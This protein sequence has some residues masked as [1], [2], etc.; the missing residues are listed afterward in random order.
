MGR[1]RR[2]PGLVTGEPSLSSPLLLVAALATSFLPDVPLRRLEVEPTEARLRGSDGFAQIVVTG[3]TK[4]DRLVDLTS[5]AKYES[6]DRRIVNVAHDGVLH[7]T[8]DGATDVVV[9]AGELSQTI[10][11]VVEDFANT[12][13][14]G[15]SSEVE[16]VFTK[17]GCNA[18][19]CHGKASGQNGFKLSLLGFDSK[20]DYD[21]IAKEA[22]GRR[23]FP[24]SPDRSLLLT[25]P[26]AQVP[27][28][29]G[30]K[31]TV[32]SMEYATLLRWVT[33]GMPFAAVR[34][35]TLVKVVV[36]PE[37]RVIPRREK[38]RLRVTA[39]YDDGTLL[40]VTRLAQYQ[41]NATDLAVVDEK[42]EITT[43]EGVGEAAVMARFGGLVA[44]TRATIPLGIDIPAWEP[45]ASRNVIDPFVFRKLRA[46]GI[47]PSPMC[48]D[49]EFARRTSLAICGVLPNPA[50]VDA[51]EADG[52]LDKRGTWVDRLL[53]RPEYADFF[54]LKWSA[55]LRNQRTGIAAIG[56]N[57][58]SLT[59]AFHAWIRQSLAENKPY[60]QFA[61]E[62]IAAKGD[63]A[64]NPPVSWYRQTG[65][66]MDDLVDDSAQLFLGMRIQ[67]ARCHHHPFEKWSQD[68]YF[69]FASFFSRVGRKTGAD[70]GSQ[71]LYVLPTGV[72]RNPTTGKTYSPKALDG[73]ELG[74]LGPRQDPRQELA[75]WL[76]RA[77]NPYF[78]KALVN[79][80]WKH[81]FGRGLVEPEDDMRVSNPPTNPEL[82]D[83]LAADFVHSGY[84]LKRLARTI[85]TS[86]AFDRSSEPNQF[87]E[88][89]HQNFARYYPTRLS[90]EVLLDAI[91]NVTGSPDPFAGVPKG[92]KAVQLPDEGFA[93]YFLDVFG[94]PKRESVCECER[95]SEANLSQ[96]LHLLNSGEIQAKLAY[97]AG[98]VARWADGA[99]TRTDREKIVELYRL[100]YSRRPTDE[101]S[102][103]C[104]TH[105]ERRKAENKPRQGYEDLVW[106]LIN[107]KEFLFN[108]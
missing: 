19:G 85:A 64:A 81:F 89:D 26:T 35:P 67:C 16:P 83:A 46:L 61:A 11:V 44:V 36:S 9:T 20:F 68:D 21:A 66:T 75:D 40:D 3:D 10:R 98:N 22:R 47:P 96:T 42:G 28:G 55:I 43:L 1:L 38:Q 104:S 65:R 2:A 95:S 87:N 74:E 27:H 5:V 23:V 101:E 82:L 25:K 45:P 51:F 107:T 84:D 102:D 70:P 53:D 77:D 52:N 79:R 30:R 57:V 24:A 7:A 34:E 105:I 32:G 37:E 50:A 31:M 108:H 86:R 63:M 17:L 54:A 71:R 60:D 69:G 88:N 33:Q 13:L 99:D 93:S 106:T 41:S 12:R 14:V 49:A 97:R 48:S 100:C 90:A 59:F 92:S 76:R 62:I 6:R 15:F 103:V 78:A 94:R 73:P 29:G 72:A 4:D 80:Y 18:G 56:Q 91:N 58:Q 39:A 8:G